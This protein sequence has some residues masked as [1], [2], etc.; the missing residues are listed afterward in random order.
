MV[1]FDYAVLF[2]CGRK[3][4][5]VTYVSSGYLRKVCGVVNGFENGSLMEIFIF[6]TVFNTIQKALH[7][8]HCKILFTK[9]PATRFVT[10]YF[11]TFTLNDSSFLFAATQ[12]LILEEHQNYAGGNNEM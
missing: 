6:S 1:F 10:S 7:V 11:V 5:E 4:E 12:F 3:I 2:I 9:I 8:K